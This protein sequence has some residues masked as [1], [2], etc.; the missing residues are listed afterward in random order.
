MKEIMDLRELIIINNC[1]WNMYAKNQELE[2]K[3][4]KCEQYINK[5][6][7]YKL[8][9][10]NYDNLVELL[11]KTADIIKNNYINKEIDIKFKKKLY[12]RIKN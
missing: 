1:K 12:F 11:D 4:S 3:L 10:L 8:L 9:K 7:E 5:N 6:N 2:N